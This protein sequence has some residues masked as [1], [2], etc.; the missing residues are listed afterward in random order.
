M[1]WEYLFLSPDRVERARQHIVTD[2][3]QFDLTE[4]YLDIE[5]RPTRQ[6]EAPTITMPTE[7]ALEEQ[8]GEVRAEWLELCLSA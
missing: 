4:S 2:L 6:L 5:P 3:E 8:K 1:R 7:A